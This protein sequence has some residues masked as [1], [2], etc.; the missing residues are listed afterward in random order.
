MIL[1]G[2][3]KD[4]QGSQLGFLRVLNEGSELGRAKPSQASPSQGRP[5][6]ASQASQAWPLTGQQGTPWHGVL[7]GEG[8]PD[9]A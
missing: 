5:Q 1:L 9:T 6:P 8:V 3:S 2:F 4:S 7:A